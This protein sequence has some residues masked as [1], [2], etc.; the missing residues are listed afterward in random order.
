[1]FYFS[2]YLTIY[3]GDEKEIRDIETEIR[4][5]LESR[6]IYIKPTLYQQKEGFICSAPYNF[7]TLMV[8][9]LMNTQPLSSAFPFISFDLSS[10]E[11]ILYGLNKHNNSLILFDRFTLPNANQV[12]FGLSGGGK[13]YAV[14]L[15]ILRYLMLGVD[16]VIIDPE[17]EYKFLSDAVGGTFFNISLSSD[18]H[19]NSFDLPTPKED[20][21]PEDVLRTNIINLVG[22]IRIMLGGMTPEEDAIV[23]KALIEVYAAKEISP[24]TY[25]SL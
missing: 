21:K 2:L 18:N 20:E 24:Q 4:S 5:I 13:S 9:T 7:D 19:I 3:G 15:E 6:L 10:N 14:K 17:N 23:D 16:V 8:T 25:F 1:M 12:V 22:L 11:G